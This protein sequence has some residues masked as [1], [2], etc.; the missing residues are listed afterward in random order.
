MAKAVQGKGGYKY[1]GGPP[2]PA[3][4]NLGALLPGDGRVVVMGQAVNVWAIATVAALGAMLLV[5]VICT[6]ILYCDWQGRRR[7]SKRK[8]AKRGAAGGRGG[9]RSHDPKGVEGCSNNA[10]LQ[11]R[12]TLTITR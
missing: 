12:V 3:A 9:R 8:R 7:R 6:G 10:F 4:D 5:I 2:G 1:D 11:C